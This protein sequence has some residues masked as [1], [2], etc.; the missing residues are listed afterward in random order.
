MEVSLTPK[1]ELDRM[2]YS[3]SGTAYEIDEAS[4]KTLNEPTLFILIPMCRIDKN[5][6]EYLSVYMNFWKSF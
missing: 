5:I 6:A 2:I 4:L 1:Q 3:F